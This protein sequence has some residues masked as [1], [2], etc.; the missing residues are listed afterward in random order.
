MSDLIP[1]GKGTFLLLRRIRSQEERSNQRNICICSFLFRQTIPLA[2]EWK[3]L[4][5]VSKVAND[6][7][8]SVARS[9]YL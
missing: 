9:Q 7:S 3:F 4:H 5:D 6:N 1:F 2:C 8:W